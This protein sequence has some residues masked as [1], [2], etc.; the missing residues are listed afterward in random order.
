MRR[1]LKS[2]FQMLR[3]KRLN[4]VIATDTYF[5][6]TKSIEG[7]HCAQVFFDMTSK[8]LYVAGMKTESEFPDV[9]LDFI[10]QHGIPSA[11]RRDN[12]KSEMSQ[13]VRQIHRDLVIADQWTE[14][15]SPWQ[16]PAEL[17]GVKYL[18]SHAQV[19]LDRTGAPDTMWFL[20]QDYLAHVHNLSANR[21]INWKIPEQVSRGGTPDISHIL[22]FY[23]FEPVLYLDPVSKFPETTERPGHFVG[24]ADNVGDKLTFKILKNDLCTV[25]HRS[26]VR[27]A[28]DANHRNK[29]VSF[30]PDVQEMINKLDV[31]PCNLPGNSHSK[32]KTRKQN[33]DVA[34]RTRSKTGHLEQNVGNRTRSKLQAIC[35]SSSQEVFFPFMM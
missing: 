19:L 23:W 18:K 22:M 7:F 15:H 10:R 6:S 12:A 14:P 26:V 27:S 33:D 5:S 35:N 28:A 3:H 20:A 4:E 11:L 24:F 29:R 16:N 31:M 34:S 1:H 21:Q 9:Y 8:M 17:N 13:R 25:L 32:Q 2:R 30:K